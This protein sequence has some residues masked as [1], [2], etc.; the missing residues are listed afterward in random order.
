MDLINDNLF[1]Q[2]LCLY[3]RLL[4]WTFKGILRLETDENNEEDH[5]RG[6]QMTHMGSMGISNLYTLPRRHTETR[7]PWTLNGPEDRHVDPYPCCLLCLQAVSKHGRHGGGIQREGRTTPAPAHIHSTGTDNI[8][9]CLN[10]ML[11][12]GVPD[13]INQT[14][15]GVSLG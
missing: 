15:M 6:K 2:G 14:L 11:K 5:P 10:Y 7:V 13:T 3:T 1:S 8:A 12:Y 9:A 4:V